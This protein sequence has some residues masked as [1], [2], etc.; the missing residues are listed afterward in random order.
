M[1]FQKPDDEEKLCQVL[2]AFVEEWGPESVT[3]AVPKQWQEHASSG[4]GRVS[5]ECT[6]ERSIHIRVVY[7]A[8]MRVS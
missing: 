8:I 2:K 4:L 6:T 5:L 1:L 7:E 3:V